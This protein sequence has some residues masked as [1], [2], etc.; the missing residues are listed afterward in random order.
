SSNQFEAQLGKVDTHTNNAVFIHIAHTQEGCT[1]SGNTVVSTQL[2]FA[3]SL[4]KSVAYAHYFTGRFHFW[5]K[6]RVNCREF[7]EREY[8]FFHAEIGWS[9]FLG[10]TL[11]CQRSAR[12]A[13]RRPFGEGHT[14][15]LGHKTHSA[16]C[17][18]IYFD[19]INLAILIGKLGIHQTNN[20]QF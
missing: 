15:A 20:A 11:L 9:N 5:P 13:A 8:R 12:L 14:N 10:E 4:A 17:A 7:I 16:R 18:W 1:C 6:D 19:Y 3:V 2:R